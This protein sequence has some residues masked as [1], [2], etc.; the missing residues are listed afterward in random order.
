MSYSRMVLEQIKYE[1][2]LELYEEYRAQRPGYQNILDDAESLYEQSQMSSMPTSAELDAFEA[3]FGK[4]NM[5]TGKRTGGALGT[6]LAAKDDPEQIKR[7]TGVDVSDPAARKKISVELGKLSGLQD[8]RMSDVY[9]RNTAGGSLTDTIAS[10]S[11]DLV[12]GAME[13]GAM[14][15][16]NTPISKQKKLSGEAGKL[17]PGVDVSVD[18][19]AKLDD[20]YKGATTPGEGQPDRAKEYL[21]TMTAI[22]GAVNDSEGSAQQFLDMAKERGLDFKPSDDSSPLAF[23]G[24]QVGL[25]TLAASDEQ[26]IAKWADKNADV[27]RKEYIN[28]QGDAIRRNIN[29]LI[30]GAPEFYNKNRGK[31]DQLKSGLEGIGINPDMTNTIVN[32]A[33]TSM[34]EP[35]TNA[36]QAFTS[37]P[38]AKLRQ[39]QRSFY[40]PGNYGRGSDVSGYRET[41]RRRG[42]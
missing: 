16:N 8:V 23:A 7:L 15:R 33:T 25:E 26:R 24:R 39:Q 32:K 13:T 17:V 27:Y 41:I 18:Q 37:S 11:S 40:G 30:P 14:I 31:L 20:L 2:Q 3:A 22:G 10:R 4:Y 29:S 35:V 6:A 12:R 9:D 19:L 5:A 36:A 21:N 34:I 1:S 42:R 28:S 38:E